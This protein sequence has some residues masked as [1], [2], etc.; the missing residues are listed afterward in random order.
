MAVKPPGYAKLAFDPGIFTARAQRQRRMDVWRA[1]SGDVGALA[2]VAG[3][4]EADR[5]LIARRG[6]AWGL[7]HQVAATT[8][9]VEPPPNR[10]ARIVDGNGWDVVELAAGSR[11]TFGTEVPGG[12]DL[13]MRFRGA[14]EGR[15]VHDRSFRLPSADAR[16]AS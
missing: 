2:T 7:I 13:E 14:A 6:S 12:I 4:Y 5:I 1:F 8:A 10:T 16:I 9:L 3:E 15:S 11:L